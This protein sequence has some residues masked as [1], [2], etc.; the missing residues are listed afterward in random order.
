MSMF[1]TMSSIGSG[2]NAQQL[3]IGS[4]RG[5]GFQPLMQQGL[6]PFQAQRPRLMSPARHAVPSISQNSFGQQSDTPMMPSA[7][8]PGIRH[9]SGASVQSP[10][11]RPRARSRESRRAGS[12][13]IPSSSGARQM[14]PQETSEWDTMFGNIMSRVSA[15]ERSQRAQRK[16][17]ADTRGHVSQLKCNLKC[18]RCR[19]R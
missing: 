3:I 18:Y 5:G 1:N 19:H 17:L 11:T 15:L 9:G 12:L 10:G 7:S 4:H 8:G 14:G 16:T 13:S 2:T 6:N